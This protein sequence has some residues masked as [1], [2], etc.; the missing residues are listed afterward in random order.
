MRRQT[1]YLAVR[2]GAAASFLVAAVALPRGPV[3]GVLV[4]VAGLVAVMACLG[5]NAGGPGE[6][7]GTAPQDR[8]FDSIRP[9]QGDWPPYDPDLVVEGELV[10]RPARRE[11]L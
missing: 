3:A 7:A 9:P 6:R 1:T 5:V 10:E 4:M 8:W 11:P 2:G